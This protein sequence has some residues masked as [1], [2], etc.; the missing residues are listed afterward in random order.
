MPASKTSH[1][2]RKSK[3]KRFFLFV[4]GSIIVLILGSSALYYLYFY[5]QV[6]P[7]PPRRVVTAPLFKPVVGDVQDP[8]TDDPD[9]SVAQPLVPAFQFKKGGYLLSGTVID[10]RTKAP[11]SSAIV[12]ID[13]PPQPGQST[14]IA[15]HTVTDATGHYQFTRLATGSYT[16]VASRYSLGGSGHYYGERIFSGVSLTSNRANL[17]LALDAI[18]APGQR[19]LRAG[20]A[21]N[22]I[23]IDLRGFYA[24]SLLRD[25]LLL[26]QTR[27]FR[28]FLQR[29]NVTDQVLLPYGWRAPDQYA[30][31]TGTYPGWSS[32]DPW[33]AIVPWGQPDNLDTTF[34][35]TGGRSTHLFGQESIFDVARGYGMQTSAITGNDFIL[36]DATTRSLDLLQRS[37]SF[38][39]DRWLTQME[40]AAQSGQGQANGFLIYSELAS[41]PAGAG[42]ASPD[43]RSDDY[44]Q[45]LLLADQTFGRFL[46]WL[47]QQG[48]QKNTL[49]GLTTSQAQANHTD[50]D[51]FYGM[52]SSGQGSSKQTFLALSGPG[53]CAQTNTQSGASGF[54]IAPILMHAIDLPAPA[55]ARFPSSSLVVAGGCK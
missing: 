20:E 38:S 28:T 18:P 15:L 33:P 44:Q 23:L 14:S 8:E 40:E 37:S 47:E 42:S 35:F 29:A 53:V 12:W 26:N 54:Q 51:N 45:A 21:K 17:V 3:K 39:A 1:A 10:A 32:Y 52:G 49:I 55:E 34:W 46:N 48:L 30:L 19:S 11:V 2:S 50:M 5:P 7:A 4:G 22:L 6:P 9:I 43:A 16:V 41:L 36:S 31:L 13:L 27:N 25:P 24:D